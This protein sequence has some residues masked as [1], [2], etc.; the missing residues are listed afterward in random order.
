MLDDNGGFSVIRSTSE[1]AGSHLKTKVHAEYHF[2]PFETTKAVP[3]NC[4]ICKTK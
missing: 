1:A 4:S 2:S 3:I